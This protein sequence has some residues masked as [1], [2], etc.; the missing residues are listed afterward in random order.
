MTISRWPGNTSITIW[1]GGLDAQFFSIWADSSTDEPIAGGL[2][3]FGVGV[4]EEMNRLGMIVDVSHASD[5]T[6]W[7]V[8]EVTSAP[9]IAS[10][11]NVRAIADH[12]RNMTDDMLRAVA[13]N[14][15]VVM[16]NFATL[17]TDHILKSEGL[18]SSETLIAFRTY[19][20]HD[21]DRIFSVGLD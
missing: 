7:D 17:V 3:E 18:I 11:S 21:L 5:A 8:V 15:G 12:P 19:S 20:R 1:E 4:I 16:I 6:F 2:S 10:H 13:D 9:L 14:G